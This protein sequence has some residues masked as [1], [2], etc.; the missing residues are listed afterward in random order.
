MHKRAEQVAMHEACNRDEAQTPD[1][2]H[3]DYP[4]TPKHK[5]EELARAARQFGFAPAR[6]TE[7]P[8]RPN[9]G[10]VAD[11]PDMPLPQRELPVSKKTGMPVRRTGVHETHGLPQWFDRA[12]QVDNLTPADFSH[13]RKNYV[14][15]T[16]EECARLFRVSAALVK[17][18]ER[19]T[20]SIPFAAWYVMH[21]HLQNPEIWISRCG[22]S[23]LYVEY[24]EGEAFLCSAVWP[25][26]RYSHGQLVY[27]S[28]AVSRMHSLET[29]IQKLRGRI[30]ELEEENTGLRRMFKENAIA[31]ELQGMHQRLSSLLEQI[32]TA[33]VYSIAGRRDKQETARVAA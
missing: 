13:W 30:G 14:Q 17:R 27:L 25:D 1:I 2:T 29:D 31:Q 19:G 6:R 33:D 5:A 3:A 9:T 8:R 21:C 23:D 32:N 28:Q 15:L 4:M 22:F 20:C 12:T 7:E 24:E 26:I 10:N 18:W 11:Y 16:V